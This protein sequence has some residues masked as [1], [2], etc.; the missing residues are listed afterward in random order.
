[1][2][3]TIFIIRSDISYK[4]YK[5]KIMTIFIIDKCISFKNYSNNLIVFAL[6]KKSILKIDSIL[7][8]N[9]EINI[10]KYFNNLFI[11]KKNYTLFLYY[12]I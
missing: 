8:K 11:K 12:L 2:L 1:M 5:I 4:I 7:P 10:N 3:T 6:Y 9:K